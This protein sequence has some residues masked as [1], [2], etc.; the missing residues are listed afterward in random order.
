M[1]KTTYVV[2]TPNIIRYLERINQRYLEHYI[3]LM[4]FIV[5][6]ELVEFIVV[7]TPWIVENIPN[8]WIIKALENI[9]IEF[10]EL[11]DMDPDIA[12][13]EISKEIDNSCII[14]NDKFRDGKYLR[15]KFE[16]GNRINFE[17]IEESN[18]II[19]RCDL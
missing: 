9:R 4:Q 19:L 18:K 13:F 8:W 17:L 10:S 16:I 5:K 1:K 2:D 14:S 7:I 3:A 6:N 15:Y 12:L 11:Y